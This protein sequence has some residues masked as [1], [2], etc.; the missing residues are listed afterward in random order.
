MHTLTSKTLVRVLY[1]GL[2][3]VLTLAGFR[4]TA[5][6]DCGFLNAPE[7]LTAGCTDSCVWVVPDLSGRLRRQATPWI[8]LMPALPLAP[9]TG[10]VLATPTNGFSDGI[11][12]PFGFSFFNTDFFNLKAT[13]RGCDVQCRTD[14]QLQLPQWD[15]GAPALPPNSI[16][17]LYGYISNNGGEIRTA[18][19]GEFP[20]RRF[21]ISWEN[22]PQTGCSSNELVTQVVLHET[23]NV[24]EMHIGQFA[25]CIGITAVVGIQGGMAKAP[26]VR[27]PTTRENSRSMISRGVMRRMGTP[28]PSWSIW[29]TMKS[30]AKATA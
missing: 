11:G 14:R 9:G 15:L 19:L 22:L 3:V 18:T 7:G 10:N 8:P 6:E 23:S 13:G 28:K 1:M 2:A 12:L 5:Q 4:A 21:V 17:A 24:V 29:S 26:M 16:M 30:S 20:C 25:S 27:M